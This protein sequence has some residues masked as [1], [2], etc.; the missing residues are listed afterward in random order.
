LGVGGRKRV[1]GRIK[2]ARGEHQRI[3]IRRSI[4]K[5]GL[6]GIDKSVGSWGKKKEKCWCKSKKKRVGSWGKKRM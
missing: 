1:K 3:Y 2:K 6:E 4:R 5:G